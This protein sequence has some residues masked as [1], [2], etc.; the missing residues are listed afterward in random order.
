MGLIH[1]VLASGVVLIPPD[2]PPPVGAPWPVEV[3]PPPHVPAPPVAVVAVRGGYQ[4][5]LNRGMAERLQD[6][7]DRTD[8]KQIATALRDL[9]KE[10]KEGAKPDEDT[11]ATL[12]L[13]AFVVSSQLPGFKKAMRENMG[14]GGVVITMTGLQAPA[15]KFRKPRPRLERAVGAVRGAMPLMPDDAREA[16]EALRAVA[17]TTPLFWK[18][19]PLE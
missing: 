6:I 19:D 8:E 13:V 11:A 18:V 1:L 3:A 2:V 4:V 14:P 15:V 5:S 7:L 10:K 16:V 9:A 12:E 17:R